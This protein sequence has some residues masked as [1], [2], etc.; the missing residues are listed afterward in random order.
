M[1]ERYAP[2][3]KTKSDIKINRFKKIVRKD[4]NIEDDKADVIIL[5]V[6]PASAHLNKHSKNIIII[7]SYFTV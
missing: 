7:T 5:H 3:M 2:S 4:A 1:Y 6:L